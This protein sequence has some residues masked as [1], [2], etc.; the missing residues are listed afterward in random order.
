MKEKSRL[1]VFLLCLFGSLLGLH[2]WYLG[3]YK[4]ALLFTLTGGGFGIWWISDLIKIAIDNDFI[5][6]CNGGYKEQR[7]AKREE[8]LEKISEIK[9]R[10]YVP[11]GHQVRCPKCG[12][13]QLSANK[14]GFSLGKAVAGGIILNPVL[15]VATGMIGKDKIIVTCIN[16][17]S[18]FKAGKGR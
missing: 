1:T 5:E 8:R 11:E 14:K 13:T 3:N 4:R 7:E 18:Q 9:E 15:G 17:G 6:N 16:C 10:H 12:S 2:N